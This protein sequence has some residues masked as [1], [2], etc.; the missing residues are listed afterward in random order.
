[1]QRCND[2]NFELGSRTHNISSVTIFVHRRYNYFSATTKFKNAIYKSGLAHLYLPR[3]PT[4][5]HLAPINHSQCSTLVVALGMLDSFTGVNAP[6]LT[7][8]LFLC[9]SKLPLGREKDNVEGLLGVA[10]TAES[11]LDRSFVIIPVVGGGGETPP[12]SRMPM[13]GLLVGDDSRRAEGM[14]DIDPRRRSERNSSGTPVDPRRDNRLERVSTKACSSAAVKSL[15]SITARSM[16]TGRPRCRPRSMTRIR[17]SF[18]SFRNDPASLNDSA[19]NFLRHG[20]THEKLSYG[21][22]RLNPT[23]P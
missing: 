14:L 9:R 13:E 8:V 11:E 23:V 16:A 3:H 20:S 1:M 22:P 6:D 19:E 10:V 21:I 5:Y 15:G 12:P 7:V 4:H 2:E 18:D 17:T